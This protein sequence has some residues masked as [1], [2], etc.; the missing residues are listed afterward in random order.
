MP[1]YYIWCPSVIKADGLYHLF[2]SRWPAAYGMNGW[3]E[4]SEIIRATSRSLEGPYSFAEVVLVK[5]PSYWDDKRVHNPKIMRVGNKYVLFYISSANQTGYAVADQI[6]GPWKRS[7]KPVI[8]FSNPAPLLLGRDSVYVFGRKEV[9][10]KRFSQAYVSASFNGPY[11]Q[12]DSSRTNLLPGQNELEDPCI[13]R[14]N[15]KFVVI[16][17][18]FKGSATGIVKA[19]VQYVSNDGIDYRL[20]SEGPVYTKSLHYSDLTAE[21]FKRRERPFVYTSD[22]GDPI[23][24]FTACLPKDGPALI[25]VTPLHIFQTF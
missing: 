21:V 2:A 9:A 23:A 12:L 13:W 16:C 5:R 17:S 3:L 10:G 1:G 7:D 8:P 25:L 24:L 14:K 4:H 6:S 22:Q 18:D 20:V 15:G 19:G 11:H